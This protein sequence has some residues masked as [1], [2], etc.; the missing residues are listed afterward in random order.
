MFKWIRSWFSEPPSEPPVETKKPILP[1]AVVIVPGT[2]DLAGSDTYI[3]VANQAREQGVP[4]IEVSGIGALTSEDTELVTHD[5]MFLADTGG[6]NIY[7]APQRVAVKKLWSQLTGRG[8]Y[9]V[10]S[11]AQE[12]DFALA[13]LNLPS[14]S[15]IAFVTHSRGYLPAIKYLDAFNSANFRSRVLFHDPVPGPFLPTPT[16]DSA[17]LVVYVESTATTTPGFAN[18]TPEDLG[19]EA[20]GSSLFTFP[21]HLRHSGAIH[22]KSETEYA[23]Q[24][25]FLKVFRSFL[26]YDKVSLLQL[27]LMNM[28]HFFQTMQMLNVANEQFGKMPSE[29]FSGHPET[30]AGIVGEDPVSL[31]TRGMRRD[32]YITKMNEVMSDDTTGNTTADTAKPKR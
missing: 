21:F 11:V 8:E 4:V 20:T 30:V 9:G 17:S 5:E 7:T 27:Q 24:S 16:L 6:F 31:T 19:V 26:T 3:D 25:M 29:D 10:N 12:I 32:E 28:K 13:S 22:P 23:A 18:A 1:A 14:E 2:G 15:E